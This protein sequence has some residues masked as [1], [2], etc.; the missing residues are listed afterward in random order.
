MVRNH[1]HKNSGQKNSY[2]GCPV[3]LT[4]S[5]G[6]SSSGFT[7]EK[8]LLCGLKLVSEMEVASLIEVTQVALSRTIWVGDA[9]M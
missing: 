3:I 9:D 8:Q 2:S 1:L 6:F 4:R 7:F 5:S